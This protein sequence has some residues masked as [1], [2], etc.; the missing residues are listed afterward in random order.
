MNHGSPWLKLDELERVICRF[1][2]ESRVILNA[3]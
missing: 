2:V 3:E 1:E